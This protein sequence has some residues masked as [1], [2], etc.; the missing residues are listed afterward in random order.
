MA[1]ISL[2]LRERILEALS[3]DSSSLRVGR[4]FSVSASFV[5][6]LRIQVRQTGDPAPGKAPGKERLVK[7][8][9]ERR[10][11]KLAAKRPDASLVELSELLAKATDVSVSETT[12]WRSLR[13]LGLTRKKS[14]SRPR[15]ASGRM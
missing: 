14:P 10:L 8:A 3:E 2:D 11:R 1:A 12:M 13:R 15:S 9:T 7:G 5:R 6:K 4:R